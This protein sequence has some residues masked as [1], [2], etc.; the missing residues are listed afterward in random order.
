MADTNPPPVRNLAGYG[1]LKFGWE[2]LELVDVL[3]GKAEPD[4]RLYNN[5]FDIPLSDSMRK[6]IPK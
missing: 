4:V 1:L 6:R 2:G 3:S 5:L